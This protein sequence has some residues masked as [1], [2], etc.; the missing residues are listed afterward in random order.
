MRTADQLVE[1]LLNENS[2]GLNHGDIVQLQGYL[3][4]PGYWKVD[5]EDAVGASPQRP[6]VENLDTNTGFYIDP[7]DLDCAVVILSAD[8]F[9]TRALDSSADVEE[10]LEDG[11]NF[12][13]DD[14]GA[15]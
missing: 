6:W 12:D 14:L 1:S 9:D 4:R 7:S 15:E 8:Q 2:Q 3:R 11:N 13:D 10:A 5:C